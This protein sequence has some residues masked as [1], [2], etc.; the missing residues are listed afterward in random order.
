[1]IKY[2]INTRLMYYEI[3][4]STGGRILTVA[5]EPSILPGPGRAGGCDFVQGR[6]PSRALMKSN[7]MADAYRG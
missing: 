2:S 6:G 3:Q 1:M 5:R 7:L 4:W